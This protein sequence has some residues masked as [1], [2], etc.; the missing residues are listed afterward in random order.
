MQRYLLRRAIECVAGDLR[1]VSYQ[2]WMELEALVQARPGESVVALPR[3]LRAVKRSGAM[4][5]ERGG[6]T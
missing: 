4:Y 6:N 3:G 2:H 5:I 1:R